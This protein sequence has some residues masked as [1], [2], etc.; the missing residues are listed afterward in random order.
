MGGGGAASSGSGAESSSSSSSDKKDKKKKDKKN[1]KRKPAKKKDKKKEKKDKDEGKKRKKSSA[2]S[3][4]D[5]KKEDKKDKKKKK[6]KQK[7]SA[8]SGADEKKDKK[9]EDEENSGEAQ[10]QRHN[11]AGR[12]RKAQSVPDR[13]AEIPTRRTPVTDPESMSPGGKQRTKRHRIRAIC[14]SVSH[15]VFLCVCCALGTARGSG[16]EQHGRAATYNRQG[17]K[18]ARIASQLLVYVE[19]PSRYQGLLNLVV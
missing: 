1:A 16:P 5:G 12:T 17:K 11:D 2:D 19:V 18:R 9:A 8:D 14:V 13:G 3:E 6:K 10:P 7:S 4:E 15:F